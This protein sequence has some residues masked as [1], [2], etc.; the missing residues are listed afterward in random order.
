[1]AFCAPRQLAQC[2]PQVVPKLTE[3]LADAHPKVVNAAESGVNRIAAVVRSSEV[4]KLSPFLLAALRDPSGRTGGAIDGM[5]G[6]EFVHA[7]D[8]ASLALLIPPLHRAL[9][10]RNYEL[11]KRSA[12]I[13]GSMCNNIYVRLCPPLLGGSRHNTD[14][15]SDRPMASS[16]IVSSSAERSGAA[17]G[18]A[19]ISASMNDRRLEEVL[20]NVL[21]AGESSAKARKVD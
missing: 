9:R 21:N 20:S 4:R 18:H 15:L 12:A 14:G 3:A 11:K 17:M 5:L 6:S 10:D 19:E 1:M 8:A 2:L 13:A 16:G 7:I